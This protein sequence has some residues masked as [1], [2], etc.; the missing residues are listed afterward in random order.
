MLV[1]RTPP[2]WLMVGWPVAL[3]LVYCRS[4]LGT[5]DI[6]Q[7]DTSWGP[8]PAPLSGGFYA[9]VSLLQ[10]VLSHLVGTQLVSRLYVISAVALVGFAATMAFR[11][12]PWWVGAAIAVLGIWNPWVYDRIADG[13]WTIVAGAGAM[14]LW[15]VAW[16]SLLAGRRSAR[17]VVA[18]VAS[19]V[20]ATA[21]TPHVLGMILLLAVA[22]VVGGRVWREP[23]L[24]RWL[25][26]ASGATV[27]AL[28]YGIVAFFAGGGAQSYQRVSSFGSPDIALFSSTSDPQFG[29][30]A[31][32]VG[33]Q[34]YW[35]ERIHRF[36]L[37][38]DG[39]S[40][41][42]LSAGFVLALAVT[43]A[44]LRREKVWLLMCGLIALAV[45]ASTAVPFVA[46]AA[47]GLIR[48]SPV[49]GAYREPEKWSAVWLIAEC[50]L[51]GAAIST[52]WQRRRAVAGVLAALVVTAAM[53]PSGLNVA[54]HLP[55]SLTTS[56]YPSDWR[57]AATFLRAHITDS[58]PVVALPWHLYVALPF[59]GDRVVQNPAPVVFPGT[60][61]ASTDPEVSGDPPQ[62]SPGNLGPAAMSPTQGCALADAVRAA[63]VRWVV[64]EPFL[65][66]PDDAAA[67]TRC[68]FARRFGAGPNGV[69][70]LEGTR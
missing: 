15:A 23:G 9:P 46:D 8:R 10:T 4:V 37:A 5:G 44:W 31:N 64:V 58:T 33:L 32:L 11:R 3:A 25:A 41:W 36:V 19:A 13:Q 61:L 14:F 60:I 59:A 66:G 24:L 29:L 62:G 48:L 51:G 50:I 40:W 35:A 65:E 54:I 34:G 39:A 45:S 6:L 56:T 55:E 7:I 21:F 20:L 68:G 63:G 70:I 67:L 28:S 18:V 16:W 26:V 38:Y 22:S 12:R 52:I 49:F 69:Q 47:A 17:T 1:A 53:L 43:G 27:L 57:A 30:F 2:M 42:P